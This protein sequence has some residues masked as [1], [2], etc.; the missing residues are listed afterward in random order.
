ME[1]TTPNTQ[2]PKKP[3]TPAQIA[4]SRNNGRKSKGPTFERCKRISSQNARSH[5]FSS[6]DFFAAANEDPNGWNAMHHSV[7]SVLLPANPI[8]EEIVRQIA[9]AQYNLRRLR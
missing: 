6:D 7:A 1:S 8:E 2:Q 9:H 3:R 4:A 5:G